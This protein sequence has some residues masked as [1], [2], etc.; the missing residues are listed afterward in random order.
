MGEK[1]HRITSI[2]S[3]YD[4]IIEVSYSSLMRSISNTASYAISPLCRLGEDMK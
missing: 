4:L 3:G 1:G 2:N